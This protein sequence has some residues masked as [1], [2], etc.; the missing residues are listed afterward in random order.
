M[1]S[2]IKDV[3]LALSALVVAVVA[4]W[5]ATAWRRQLKGGVEYDV[6]RRLLRS[7]YKV[8]DGAAYLRSRWLDRSEFPNDGPSLTERL[9]RPE[10]EQKG[11]VFVFSNRWNLL[12]E[13]M[14][15][16]QVDGLEAEVLWEAKAREIVNKLNE[17]VMIDLRYALDELLSAEAGARGEVAAARFYANR[18]Q[19]DKISEKV[20]LALSSIEEHARPFLRKTQPYPK[21][22]LFLSL[23]GRFPWGRRPS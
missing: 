21:T 23:K 16:F 2:I 19:T 13:A 22:R 1:V 14:R 20:R 9:Q 10:S 7:A 5:G 8:R 4:V 12:M 11:R 6:A 17:V 18:D 3:L 15:E